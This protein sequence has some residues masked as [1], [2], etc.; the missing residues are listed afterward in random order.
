MKTA[1]VDGDIL[2]YRIGYGCNDYSEGIAIKK[3]SQFLEELVYINTNC[4]DA[5]GYLTGKTNFRD[6]IA[7][8]QKYKGHRKQEKPRHL[9][10]LREYMIKAW[11]FEVQEGQEAD[12]AIGIK[13]YEMDEKECVICTID[14]DLDIIR[15]WH[16]NFHHNTLYYIS[17][18][19]AIKHFY[20]QLLTGDR[21]DN[22][23]GLEGIGNK[24]A[25][26]ILKDLT[27]EKELYKA[28]LEKYDNN[29]EY[30]LEQGRLLWIRKKKNQ[31]WKLPKL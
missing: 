29:K 20:K 12:D 31:L 1:I 24:K 14:K 13:A 19:E 22:I 25:E 11:D 30:L 6:D 26:K 5:I 28:V 21:T 8:T 16:Y 7:V 9:N 17:E 18:Q 15:G 3:L 4:D 10:I 27:K 2:A 23:R